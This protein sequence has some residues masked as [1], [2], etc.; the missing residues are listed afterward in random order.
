M[1]RARVIGLLYE[2]LET[3]L[4]LLELYQT[5]LECTASDDVQREWEECLEETEEHVVILKNMLDQLGLRLDSETSGRRVVRHKVRALIVAMDMAFSSSTAHSAQL[6]AAEC[7]VN[8]ETKS[9]AMW[10][11]IGRVSESAS[12]TVGE[13]VADAYAQVEEQEDKHLSHSQGWA[14]ELWIEA[15]AL[16]ALLPPPEE[17]RRPHRQVI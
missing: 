4:G 14:R 5:P 9:H 1:N 17:V 7:V 13:I 12:E 16:P 11:L 15:L 6:V 10:E 8:A 3:E 2:A